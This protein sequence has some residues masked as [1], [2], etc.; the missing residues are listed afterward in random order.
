[1]SEEVPLKPITKSDVHKLETAL[2]IAT[3]LRSDLLEKIKNPEDRLTW[4]DS[5]AVAAGALARE[6]A[7]YTTS[8]IADELG[9][10][11]ATIRNHLQGRTEAGRMVRETYE[12]FL[13]EGVKIEIPLLERALSVEEIEKL[14]KDLEETKKKL[15]ESE[16]KIT[17]MTNKLNEVKKRLNE[18]IS[19]L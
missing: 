14:R 5:L 7:G 2:M 13:R 11:E 9:R 15:E 19:M 1:M 18:I 3:L 17:E 4:I 6:R 16:R 10:T 8:E 12:R